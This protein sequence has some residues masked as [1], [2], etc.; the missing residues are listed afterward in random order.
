VVI[1]FAV[2]DTQWRRR[3]RSG[4]ERNSTVPVVDEKLSQ[5]VVFTLAERRYALSLFAV[6]RVVHV[7]E[8]TP[9]YC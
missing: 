6:D 9:S 2:K 7:V 3:G 5:Y 8:I 4:M 1:P